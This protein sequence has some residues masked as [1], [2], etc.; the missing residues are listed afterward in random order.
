MNYCPLVFMESSAKNRT[1]DKLDPV[2]MLRLQAICDQH[3]ESVVRSLQPSFLVGIG[4]YAERCLQRILERLADKAP[5]STHVLRILHPSP[6]SP[7][8]N[9][10]W[11]KTATSQ[12]IDGGVWRR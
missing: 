8:A 4:A 1:P 10:G 9:K 3:L 11:A 5:V 2:E 7:A 6:A 12:L